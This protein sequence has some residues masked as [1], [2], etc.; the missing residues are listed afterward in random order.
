MLSEKSMKEFQDVFEKKYGKKLSKEE[1]IESANNLLR[2]F[3]LLYKID[4]RN[5]QSKKKIKNV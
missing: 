2:F 5:K 4:C 1:A 3:E